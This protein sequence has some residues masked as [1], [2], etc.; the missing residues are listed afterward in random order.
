MEEVEE[1]SA[2][3]AR[4]SLARKVLFRFAFAYLLLYNLPFPLSV[5]PWIAGPVQSAYGALWELVVPLVADGVFGTEAPALAN[6]SGDTTFDYVQVFTYFALALA[7]AAIWSFLDRR[8][9]HYARLWE[10]L[11][12]YVRF[13]LAVMMIGYGAVKVIPTQ[14]QPPRLDRL[15]QPF[16]DASPMGILWTFMGA[17]IAYTIFAGLSEMAGG[18]LLL[19]RRTTLLGA[20]VGAGVLVNIVAMNFCYDVPVKLLSSHLL[21]MA[22]FLI[23]PDLG[24]LRNL[25]VLNRRVEPVPLQPLFRRRWLHRS[26]LVLRA[27]FLLGYAG[28]ALYQSWTVMHEY[29]DLAPKPPLH[30]IWNVDDFVVDGTPRPPLLTDEIRWR[31]MIFS[32]SGSMVIQSM[33]GSRQRYG[34][35][36]ST[37][38]KT[39]AV[40]KGDDPTWRSG[41]TYRQPGPKL[42]TVEGTFDGHKIQARLSREEPQFLLTTRGFHWINEFPF[43][44]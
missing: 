34:L 15:V 6:G 27:V 35:D 32:R 33:G 16:G 11:R 36:L 25:L 9:V 40:T 44:R 7:A 5:I 12:V 37:E 17:S 39:M 42:L 30:G 2:G 3:V 1:R 19:S 8:R 24:R 38:R 43:N 13:A 14:F 29:G 18:L 21:A 26:A 10:W 23:L 31:R 28:F 41:L 22:V 20:L 4:W